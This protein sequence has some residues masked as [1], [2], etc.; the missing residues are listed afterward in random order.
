[1]TFSDQAHYESHLE[2]YIVQQ[3]EKQGWLVGTSKN[4]HTEYALYP[5]DLMSWIKDTQKTKW[6]KL[7]AINGE[8][9]EKVLLDRLDT[10]LSKH[11]TIQVFRNGF[12][13]AGCG[14]IDLSESAPEDQRNQQVIE[15]YKANRLR[16][17]PQLK[18]N[19]TRNWEID[20]AFFINGLAVAT[21]EIKTDFNQSVEAAM[22]QYKND[23]LPTDPKTKRQEPLLTFKRGAIVHF[24]L[25]D[26]LIYMTT[27]LDGENT[28]FLPFN[29]GY[30]GHAGNPPAENGEYP[31][32]YFWEDI[33]QPDHWLKIFHSFVYVEKKN[34]V[35]LQGNWKV[36]ETLIFPRFHQWTAVNMM[37]R[38]AKANGAGQSYLCEHSAGSGKTS[39]I[40]W[41]SHELI[42]LRQADGTAI[43]NSVIVVTDRTVL[44]DQLQDAIQQIDHQQGLIAAINRKESSQSKSKQLEDALLKGVPII[45]VTIQTFPYAMEAILT[46][47]S[48]RNR[49]FGIIIDEAHAS[50]TGATA[51]KLQ[52]TLALKSNE[53]MQ[54]LTIE[55]LLTEIQNSRVR[56]KN[57]SHFAFTATPKHSTMMLFGRPTDPTRPMG[58]DNL[59]QSFH[60]YTMRQAI[61]ENFIL[62]VL[63]GYVPYN[64]A[65]NLGGKVVDD[66]RVDSKQAKRT[67]ARWM[68]L[69]A[70]NVTQKV[71]FIMQHFAKNVAH[72]LN[73]NAK[74]M[75]VTSSRAA[76]ARYKLGFDNYIAEHEEY[77]NYRVLVAFS[78]KLTGDSI[79]HEEDDQHGGD[80]FNFTDDA[81]FSEESMNAGCP[82]SDLRVAFDRPEYRLM[83]VADKFQTGFDQPKLVAMYLDKKIANE[84]EVVQTLSRL[85]RNTT[86]KDQLYIIDF[87]NDPLWIK[88][89]F[90]KYDNGAEL[91]DVQDPNVVYDIKDQLDEAALYQ[92]SDLDQ[93]R[94]ARFKTIR[95]IAKAKQPQHQALYQA[96]EA[97]TRLFNRKLKSLQDAIELQEQAFIQAK[98]Q[99]NE[100]GQKKADHERL[101]L[102]TELKAL[103]MFKGNL[104]K[105]GR[106]YAYVAQLVNFGD[107]ELENFAAF[108]KLLAKRLDGV[109][110][111]EI[112]ITGLVLTGF[113]IKPKDVENP[114][115]DEK[116]PLSGV[117]GGSGDVIPPKPPIYIDQIIEQ[118]NNIFGEATPL[119]DQAAFV[120]HVFDILHENQTVM[121]QIENNVREVAL[122][123][124]LPNAAQQAII[125]AISSH[126]KLA[127]ILLK[128]DKQSL[129]AFIDLLYERLK[130]GEKIDLDIFQ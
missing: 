98:A 24:A 54:G 89:C 81:E 60:K 4:Y 73:G 19:P 21:V 35:D 62:D 68:N 125:Q 34:V 7:Y 22:H 76:A 17:V 43:F 71:Q 18:Y 58:D 65:F 116:Q 128:Q 94:E 93:F 6:D 126:Q 83:V 33:C 70:T 40:A 108:S 5:E 101:Q 61:E 107:P 114:P 59:P 11:G 80:V 42:K 86:G 57:I 15:R 67:L 85:N 91:M 87:V 2:T 41:T 37:V 32:A 119:V 127:A 88:Q 84:V 112:D 110:A 95:D 14:E 79:K 38:D 72:L 16:V 130:K 115:E 117:S 121:A 113:D 12:S 23:R 97:P 66:K 77:Q 45:I 31:V 46:N 56:P 28:F 26:S 48:L 78:G 129:K 109:A 106:I 64:T 92:D 120:N 103:L 63:Q 75:V 9:T 39:S 49:N 47:E 13:V 124:N 55:E 20:L 29:K 105:F 10:A 123:G 74:A 96:T 104:A 27:K 118:M 36:K 50:Q 30:D 51:S 25:S 69:H 122:Q 1:M 8:R 99:G 3:L 100:D 44:D 102:D 90:A 82:N 52:A 53:E 111:Q